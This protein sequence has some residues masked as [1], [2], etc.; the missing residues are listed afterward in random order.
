MIE[1]PVRRLLGEA[2]D[3]PMPFHEHLVELR[4]RII[5]SLIILGVGSAI[6]FYFSQ[7]FL[8]WLARPV[9]QLVFI[10]PAEAFHTRFK[11]AFYGGFLLTLPLLL[12]QL[13]L[14]VARAFNKNWR[15]RLLKLVQAEWLAARGVT[16]VVTEN[17]EPN[18]AML[19]V[20]ERLG[21][22]PIGSVLSYALEPL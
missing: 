17:D 10:A 20:N 21:F 13:W 6:A 18:R 8:D 3:R 12:H 15:T 9:G 19:T 11:V 7:G 4:Q 22:R 1:A 16:C 5:Q 14:F 2:D